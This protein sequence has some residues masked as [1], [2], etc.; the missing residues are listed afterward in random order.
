MAGGGVRG[1]RSPCARPVSSGWGPDQ[2]LTAATK[3]D[4]RR[5]GARDAGS[6]QI[7][8]QDGRGVVVPAF[9]AD[10]VAEAIGRER[11]EDPVLAPS[12]GPAGNALLTAWAALVIL[13]GSLAELLT[14]VDVNGLLSWHVAI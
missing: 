3:A 12:G 4:G 11:R 2:N 13:V 5:S 7:S 1:R 6:M 8:Q 10:A 9:V 14:L